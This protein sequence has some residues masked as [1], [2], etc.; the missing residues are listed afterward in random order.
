MSLT[1]LLAQVVLP[2]GEVVHH[3][4][5]PWGLFIFFG[6]VVIIS[7]LIYFLVPKE[8]QEAFCQFLNMTLAGK[9]IT[10]L[11]VAILIVILVWITK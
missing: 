10:L 9:L 2:T 8:K 3:Q 11:V 7:T 1:N 5:F 4:T 6:A